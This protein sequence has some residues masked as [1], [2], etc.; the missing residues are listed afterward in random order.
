MTI[1]SYYALHTAPIA[2]GDPQDKN[3]ME[4]PGYGRQNQGRYWPSIGPSSKPVVAVSYARDG[5][6]THVYPIYPTVP[7]GGDLMLPVRG[8]NA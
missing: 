7:N 5:V 3:E 1:P 6:I 4:C 8:P 2:V